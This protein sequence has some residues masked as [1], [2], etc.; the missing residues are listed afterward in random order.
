MLEVSRLDL[1]DVCDRVYRKYI[2]SLADSRLAIEYLRCFLDAKRSYQSDLIILP[3]IADW[4]WH[5]LILD[6]RRYEEICR[7]FLGRFL[8]HVVKPLPP[9]Q[10]AFEK[11]LDFM[12]TTYSLPLGDRPEEWLES[13]WN[14][15]QYRLRQPIEIPPPS[16]GAC[17]SRTCSADPDCV[18]FLSW[19]PSR[20]ARRFGIP[21]TFALQAVHEYSNFFLTLRESGDKYEPCSNSLVCQIAWEEHILWTRKYDA[22][23]SRFLG[24]F[25]DHIP[26]SL[27]EGHRSSP[28]LE[29]A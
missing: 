21:A 19:L 2:V 20:I 10:T 17:K 6:T 5:E 14:R 22:D 11:S 24:F 25:L 13:G 4:A 7:S 8:H 29:C 26:R 23:C 28:L 16:V 9:D 12:R 18:E 3:Q 27:S 1:D 15:P